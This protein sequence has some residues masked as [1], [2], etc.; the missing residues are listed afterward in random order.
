ML[1]KVF[2]AS[3]T[4]AKSAMRS[5]AKWLAESGVEPVP[6]DS[7][8][9]FQPGDYILE[10]LLDLAGEVD[11]A[12]ILFGDEDRGWYRHYASVAPRDNVLIEYGIFS[13]RLGRERTIVCRTGNPKN[14]SDLGGLIWVQIGAT[15]AERD[16]AKSRVQKWARTLPDL[17]AKAD[18]HAR[19]KQNAANLRLRSGVDAEYRVS[20]T[21]VIRI[22][23]GSVREI[24][25]I[26]VIVSS[27]NTY[28][29]PAR[30]F[31]P[32]LSG[33]LRYLDSNRNRSDGRIERDT[34]LEAMQ[35]AIERERVVLPVLLGSVLVTPSN[36]LAK[37]GI[38]YVFH[39]ATVHGDVEM[40]Y[41]GAENVVD[42]AVR[43]ALARFGEIAGSEPLNSMLLPLF[44]TGAA[45]RAECLVASRLVRAVKAGLERTPQLSRACLLAYTENQRI[46]LRNSAG[47]EG[48]ELTMSSSGTATV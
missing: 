39:A 6:W 18:A 48:L 17:I 37:Q 38:K 24:R 4:P 46:A 34:Y 29:Q 21:Q 23:T 20:A 43:N 12:I 5:I 9:L 45:R 7:P 27:E 26:D 30:F 15:K 32:T 16:D 40:G 3:S 10:R 33:T 44:G 13:S 41:S 8:G 2:L 19:E 14:A 35:A 28:F 47:A 22:V 1:P 11:A 42:E 31:E 25:D 36:A